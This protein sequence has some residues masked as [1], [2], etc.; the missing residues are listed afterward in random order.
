M[1]PEISQENI[2]EP[3]MEQPGEDISPDE[4][5]ASLAFATK[6]QE[7]MMAEAP[8][9][10]ENAPVEGQNQKPEQDATSEIESLKTQFSEEIKNVRK[11]LKEDIKAELAEI[12]EAIKEAIGNDEEEES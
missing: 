9:M 8:E 4:A 11:E 1:P 7:G 12:K 3:M 5:A 2:E 10:G 6:L